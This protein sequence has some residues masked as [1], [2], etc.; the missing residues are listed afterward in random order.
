[1]RTIPDISDLLVPLDEAIDT[2]FIP[3]LTGRDSISNPERQLLSLPARLGGLGLVPSQTASFEHSSSVKV[4]APL[5]ALIVQQNPILTATSSAD[6]QQAKQQG[7]GLATLPPLL[8]LLRPSITAIRGARS[9]TG[10]AA[11][12]TR[13]WTSLSM[14][15]MYPYRSLSFLTVACNVFIMQHYPHPPL[16]VCVCLLSCTI[17][18][19]FSSRILARVVLW[20][21]LRASQAMSIVRRKR[22]R[23]AR[24]LCSYV[25]ERRRRKTQTPNAIFSLYNSLFTQ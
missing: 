18:Q 12:C 15:A 16:H 25:I 1:M 17:I 10:H 8:S 19:L 20:R 14:K 23:A 11:R 22:R 6:Q 5:A 9:R 4:T 7:H 13:Q 3:A 24:L 21:R 2:Y